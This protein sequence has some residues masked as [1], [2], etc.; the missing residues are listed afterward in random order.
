MNVPAVWLVF[1]SAVLSVLHSDSQS[2]IYYELFR[3]ILIKI[4]Y[5]LIRLH[6]S[7]FV[8]S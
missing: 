6:K 8:S 7:V 3:S 5:T 2:D 1:L 4:F